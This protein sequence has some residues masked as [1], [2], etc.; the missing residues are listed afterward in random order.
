MKW[1]K[2]LRNDIS[3]IAK[4]LTDFSS[5]S[6]KRSINFLVNLE[7][8]FPKILEWNF[9]AWKQHWLNWKNEEK[10]KE[11]LSWFELSH[12]FD[13]LITRIGERSFEKHQFMFSVAFLKHFQAHVN[14]RKDEYVVIEGNKRYYMTDLFRLFYNVLFKFVETAGLAEKEYFWSVFPK[15]WKITKKDFFN[16]ARLSYN[17][18][19]G[20]ARSRIIDNRESD[21]ILNEITQNLFPEVDIRTWSR[22]LIFVFSPYGENRVKSVIDRNWSFGYRIRTIVSSGEYSPEEV[23]QQITAE[24]KTKIEKAYELGLFLYKSI[25][26]K[27]MLNEYKADARKLKYRPNTS[28]G[29]KKKELLEIFDGLLHSLQNTSAPN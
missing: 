23:Y 11:W 18:F 9:I 15:E 10:R 6:E 4:L 25:S 7:E 29:R 2:S 20:W 12:T 13:T 14:F 5:L 24:D 26:T 19:M 1:W 3:T 21:L 22:I 16:L 8:V 17:N 27:K 28:E